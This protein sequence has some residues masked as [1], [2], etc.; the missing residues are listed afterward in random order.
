[1][2]PNLFESPV[3]REIELDSVGISGSLPQIPTTLGVPHGVTV[4]RLLMPSIIYRL[5]KLLIECPVFLT[6]Q[7]LV[8]G[9]L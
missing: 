6:N 9:F 4:F 3:I 8:L 2:L 7:L 1:M 5:D